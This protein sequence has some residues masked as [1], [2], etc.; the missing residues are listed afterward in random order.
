[1]QETNSKHA[2]VLETLYKAL[3]KELNKTREN[4]GIYTLLRYYKPN[5]H[6]GSY[7]HKTYSAVDIMD[8]YD[9]IQKGQKPI[10]DPKVFE[11]KIVI[12]GANVKAGSGRTKKESGKEG[13]KKSR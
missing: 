13:R 4:T 7:S 8:S 5:R 6:G 12:V 1:M 11:N 2:I 3:N 10:L 9:A